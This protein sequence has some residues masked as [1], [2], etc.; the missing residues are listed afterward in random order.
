MKK[1]LLVLAILSLVLCVPALAEDAI[2]SASVADFYPS[3]FKSRGPPAT[4]PDWPRQER[5]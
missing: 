5:M 1:L 3:I 4:P 2:S